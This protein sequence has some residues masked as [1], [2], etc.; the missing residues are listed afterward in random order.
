LA[1]NL[2]SKRLDL[3][4]EAVPTL[5]RLAVMGNVG[6]PAS[7]LEMDEVRT[8]ART[9]GLE[10]VVLELRREEDF[11]PAFET[12]KGRVDA[13]YLCT[14]AL[15]DTHRNR[16]HTFSLN[17]RLPTMYGFRELA[18]TAGLLSYGPSFPDLFRRAGDYVD[19]ILRGAKPGDIPVEQPTKFEFVINLKTAKALGLS[20]PPSLL[21]R[22]DEV[23][24]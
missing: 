24:E 15:I 4:R 5:R 10:A 22:A 14:D 6:Y 8:A 16:I 11:A 12:L 18:E 13:L 20:V 1:A 17:A 9:L 19:K 7:V 2:G 23:I 21:A 3:L